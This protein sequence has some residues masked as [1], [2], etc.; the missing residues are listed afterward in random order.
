MPLGAPVDEMPVFAPVGVA[1]TW[2]Q[3]SN[4]FLQVRH[5]G[6][7]ASRAGRATPG[8]W[9]EEAPKSHPLPLRIKVIKGG[10]SRI[11]FPFAPSSARGAQRPDP[12][13]PSVLKDQHRV[14]LCLVEHGGHKGCNGVPKILTERPNLPAASSFTTHGPLPLFSVKGR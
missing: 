7:V 14:A 2:P 6:S 9:R 11:P 10:I 1:F 3:R 12:K 8:L 13:C 4:A 5:C